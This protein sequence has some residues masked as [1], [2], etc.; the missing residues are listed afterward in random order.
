MCSEFLK[1]W[2]KSVT[3][4]YIC[5]HKKDALIFITNFWHTAIFPKISM[6][7]LNHLYSQQIIYTSSPTFGEHKFFLHKFSRRASF[8]LQT[9]KMQYRYILPISGKICIYF[10]NSL[11]HSHWFQQSSV[12][13]PMNICRRAPPSYLLQANT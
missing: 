3:K 11:F 4:N 7:K 8:K 1:T 5:L 13:L 6:S 2:G 9:F 12:Q 10:C